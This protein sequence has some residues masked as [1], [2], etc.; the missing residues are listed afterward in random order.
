[1]GYCAVLER[2]MG[3]VGQ[4]GASRR[5]LWRAEVALLIADPILLLGLGSAAA[6]STPSAA[7][8]SVQ[9]VATPS[10]GNVPLTVTLTATVSAGTPTN[11]AW[12]FGDGGSWS[13]SGVGALSVEHRYAN[14][15]T[16]SAVATVTEATGTSYGT[17]SVG[18]VSGPLVAVISA[19]PSSGSAPLSV[20]FHALISGGT[21]TY[22]SFTWKFGDG[23]VGAGPVVTYLYSHGGNFVAQL[24]VVDSSNDTAAGSVALSVSFAPAPGSALSGIGPATLATAGIVGAGLT[25]GTYYGVRR[26][27][28]HHAEA[29]GDEY[30]ALPPGVYGPSA[31]AAAFVAA[32]VAAAA[33]AEESASSG[34]GSSGT[35]AAASASPRVTPIVPSLDVV[36]AAPSPLLRTIRTRS[37]RA[38]GEEP[39]RWSRD[40]VAYLGSLPTLGP[41]DIA[42][43]DWTQK[44]MS[45]RL[46]T[47]QNQ[48]SNVLRRLVASGIVVERLEH[49]QGQPRRLKVYRL[50]LR[51]EALAREVRRRRPI[52]NPNLLRREW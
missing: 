37:A 40:I 3:R 12:T 32:P 52:S 18:V 2:R 19:S 34:L 5:A 7:P 49:V 41:D 48:V 30:G 39:R 20:T 25:F 10:A 46:H 4:P 33:T 51:G 9:V 16:F 31:G 35:E 8:F 42:T 24:T 11:V 14:V 26:R 21:G 6:H 23:G 44:G 22:T 47:G 17:A 29:E 43:L 27:R 45:D 13:G 50:T 15:G 1:L 36:A 38:P 28:Q